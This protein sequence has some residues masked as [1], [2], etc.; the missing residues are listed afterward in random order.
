VQSRLTYTQ[1]AVLR[2]RSRSREGLP[3]ALETPSEGIAHSLPVHHTRNTPVNDT[4]SA[5]LQWE[6]TLIQMPNAIPTSK[7][8]LET[9]TE[10]IAYTP[11]VPR[12]WTVH[13]YLLSHAD[14]C[15]QQFSLLKGYAIEGPTADSSRGSLPDDQ[16]TTCAIWSSS[17]VKALQAPSV[18]AMLLD[19]AIILQSFTY[20][21]GRCDGA[22]FNGNSKAFVHIRWLCD[23]CTNSKGETHENKVWHAVTT[24][25]QRFALLCSGVMSETK[26]LLHFLAM[27]LQASHLCHTRCLCPAHMFPELS[28]TNL[29]RGAC[30]MLIRLGLWKPQICSHQ[31]KCIPGNILPKFLNRPWSVN[32]NL[33][34]LHENNLDSFVEWKQQVTETPAE[35]IVASENTFTSLPDDLFKKI[36]RTAAQQALRSEE[37]SN[38]YSSTYFIFRCPFDD[39]TSNFATEKVARLRQHL[40]DHNVWV[41]RE[42]LS[43]IRPFICPRCKKGYSTLSARHQHAIAGGRLRGCV[44]KL[45]EEGDEENMRFAPINA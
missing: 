29:G 11:L 15:L 37:S 32:I 10:G 30:A 14:W 18:K 31:P 3:A 8:S 36:E 4:N 7:P 6:L 16:S 2:R 35:G 27:S 22:I 23:G 45:G 28:K 41:S 9:P 33:T 25:V 38:P 20:P 34:D 13:P 39:C 17:F 40:R 26:D 44:V 5:F 1:V 21:S 24:G 42:R 12:T 43:S 19:I